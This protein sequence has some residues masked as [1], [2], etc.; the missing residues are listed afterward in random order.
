MLKKIRKKNQ[1]EKFDLFPPRRDRE[2]VDTYND[3]S[4]NKL[5]DNFHHICDLLD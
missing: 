1:Y 4:E 3:I 2:K 5:W